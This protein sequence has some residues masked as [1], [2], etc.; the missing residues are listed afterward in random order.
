MSFRVIA[1]WFFGLL[2]L[3]VLFGHLEYLICETLK[4]VVVLGLVLSL[5]VENADLIQEALK[6]TRPR[7]VFL[8][9]T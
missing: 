6:F 3:I 1:I 5:R 2:L 4:S 9:A 8:V 7:P